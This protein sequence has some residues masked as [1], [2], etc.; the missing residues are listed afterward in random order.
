MPSALRATCSDALVKPL[1]LQ[2]SFLSSPRA[3]GRASLDLSLGRS[4]RAEPLCGWTPVPEGR[5]S[6]VA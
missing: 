5:L 4:T 1:S 6:V 3:A 2:P